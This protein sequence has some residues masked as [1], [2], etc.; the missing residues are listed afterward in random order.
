MH[1]AG[2]WKDGRAHDWQRKTKEHV[3]V[4]PEFHAQ[5]KTWARCP[6]TESSDR[7]TWELLI[8]PE[9]TSTLATSLFPSL[10]V[11]CQSFFF[12]LVV[13]RLSWPHFTACRFLVPQPGFEPGPPEVEKWSPNHWIAREFPR[14]FWNSKWS[15]QVAFG[16]L[17]E[18]EETERPDHWEG[19]YRVG[20]GSKFWIERK[21]F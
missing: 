1:C 2:V 17:T 11:F 9:S 15:W 14:Q 16:H 13:V 7:Q 3:R 10:S 8:A 12:F 20:T 5:K 19:D 18:R 6:S 21:I 4:F